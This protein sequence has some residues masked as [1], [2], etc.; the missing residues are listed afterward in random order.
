MLP[1]GKLE[2]IDRT[3]W[4]FSKGLLTYVLT[5]TD[6]GTIDA[7]I[8]NLRQTI[9]SICV[10]GN[11]SEGD[12]TGN[13]SVTI[14]LGFTPKAAFVA[15][16]YKLYNYL[17]YG[18]QWSGFTNQINIQSN[19][20]SYIMIVENGIILNNYA[21]NYTLFNDGYTAHYICFK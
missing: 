18:N 11:Y 16:Q 4:F 13:K 17:D 15:R 20:S 7:D 6:K 3:L 9:N 10:V 12:S 5:G 19:A 14:N 2:Y 21:G 8:D 1:D